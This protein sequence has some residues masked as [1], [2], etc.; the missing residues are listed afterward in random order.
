[1]EIIGDQDVCIYG[2]VST[3]WGFET[4]RLSLIKLFLCSLELHQFLVFQ[5]LRDVL[6]SWLPTKE[7]TIGMFHHLRLSAMSKSNIVHSGTSRS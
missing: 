3:V 5:E 2:G 4:T 1:M 7:R 6:P